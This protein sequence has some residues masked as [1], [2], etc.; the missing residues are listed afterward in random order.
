ME[1]LVTGANELISWVK[2]INLLRLQASEILFPSLIIIFSLGDTTFIIYAKYVTN[3]RFLLNSRYRE[4]RWKKKQWFYSRRNSIS[5]PTF[6]MCDIFHKNKNDLISWKK[7]RIYFVTYKRHHR[8]KS[9][10]KKKRVNS[11]IICY[12]E[13]SK[14]QVSTNLSLVRKN[15]DLSL[16]PYSF[17]NHMSPRSFFCNFF[18]L[19]N[20]MTYIYIS[21]LTSWRASH[22]N[23]KSPA[24]IWVHSYK[25]VKARS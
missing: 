13:M 24:G 15:N 3:Q 18:V 11:V 22:L 16:Y 12:E 10:T 2:L 1:H 5:I 19:S 20:K 9:R 7:Y 25:R 8:G 17:I 21:T 14:K 23:I 6:Y 4:K